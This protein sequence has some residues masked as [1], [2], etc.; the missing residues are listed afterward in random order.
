M[1]S[2]KILIKA[3]GKSKDYFFIIAFSFSSLTINAQEQ[4]EE[5]E[6]ITYDFRSIQTS[7]LFKNEP[8]SGLERLRNSHSIT[9]DTTSFDFSKI[10]Q[11]KRDR[12]I[13]VMEAMRSADQQANESE[14]ARTASASSSSSATP[15]E[16]GTA[17][18][19]VA[20]PSPSSLG[21]VERGTD[22]VNLY[23]GDLNY[24]IPLYT[25]ESRDLSVPIILSYNSASNKVDN[26]S[27][28]VGMGWSLN[29]GGLITRVMKG[30]PDEFQGDINQANGTKYTGYGWL[31]LKN[32]SMGGK[33]VRINS[34]SDFKNRWTDVNHRKN[35]IEN[36]A[37][38]GDITNLYT[39]T[40]GWDTEP[41]EFYYNFGKYS[42]K[43]VFTQDGN[44]HTVPYQEFD[45]DK[46]T[47]TVNGSEKIIGFSVLT[48][49]GVT[50]TFG[51]LDANNL[52][53]T[54]IS[55]MS[56]YSNAVVYDYLWRDYE[57]LA[58]NPTYGYCE[59]SL[60]I[61]NYFP[62]VN[63]TFNA[64][65]EWI[66]NNDN[67]AATSYPEFTSTWHLTKIEFQNDQITLTYND[68]GEINYFQGKSASVKMPNL[69]RYSLVDADGNLLDVISVSDEAPVSSTQGRYIHPELSYH[70]R[71]YQYITLQSKRLASIATS[72]G[73]VANFDSYGLRKDLIGSTRLRKIRI[74]QGTREVVAFRFDQSYVESPEEYYAIWEG[75]DFLYLEDDLVEVLVKTFDPD[76]TSDDY[77]EIVDAEHH[78]LKL[79]QIVEI[80]NGSNEFPPT[81]FHYN[82]T[83]L[84]RR[85]SADQ[86]KWGYY[87]Y[88]A[89]NVLIPP[90]SYKHIFEGSTESVDLITWERVKFNSSTTVNELI[91]MFIDKY[92]CASNN[93][94]RRG[95]NR[96][97]HANRM[98]AGLLTRID[99][100]LGGSTAFEYVSRKAA[101]N[102]KNPTVGG[103]KV[104]RISHTSNDNSN[105]EVTQFTFADGRAPNSVGLG[106]SLKSSSFLTDEIHRSYIFSS[107][108]VTTSYLTHGSGGGF[109]N[110]TVFKESKGKTLYEFI[111]PLDIE[112]K[113]AT[114][115]EYNL[116]N[117]SGNNQY[118]FAPEDNDWMRGKVDKVS[119]FREGES[120]PFLVKDYD[121]E[122]S[123]Q[124]LLWGF[125]PGYYGYRGLSLN[126]R[127][128][129]TV[130][131]GFPAYEAAFYS[132]NSAVYRVKETIETLAG[133]R[134]VN[135]VSTKTTSFDYV[136]EHPQYTRGI[137]TTYEDGSQ[138]S[139]S[140]KYVFDYFEEGDEIP[141]IAALT[142][143]GLWDLKDHDY[144]FTS[145][146]VIKKRRATDTDNWKIV[147]G[148]LSTF[149]RGSRFDSND[150]SSEVYL[151]EKKV[152]I[153][154]SPVPLSSFTEAH[155]NANKTSFINDNRYK[156]H[157]TFL[158]YNAKG[159]PILSSDRTGLKTKVTW[160]NYNSLISS[161]TSNSG[162]DIEMKTQ[163]QYEPLVGIKQVKDENNKA[164]NYIYDELNRLYMVKD[165]EG[166]IMER[167]RYNYRNQSQS[168]NFYT[169]FRT[170]GGYNLACSLVRFSSTDT[171]PYGASE[172]TWNFGDSGV[173]EDCSI[174]PGGD[175]DGPGTSQ[176]TKGKSV[177]HRFPQAGTYDV[178]VTRFSPDI[179]KEVSR[180]NTIT[181]HDKKATVKIFAADEVQ[182]CSNGDDMYSASTST[183][184]VDEAVIAPIDDDGSG[185]GNPS[186]YVRIGYDNDGAVCN[187]GG[188]SSAS[189]SYKDY[190][191][192]WKVFSN[193]STGTLPDNVFNYQSAPFTIE[194]KGTF[195]DHCSSTVYNATKTINIVQCSSGSSGGGG[196]GGGT[197]GGIDGPEEISSGGIIKE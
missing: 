153:L 162:G 81:V 124:S 110:V 72:N 25:L 12:I 122:L 181:I 143:E 29:A 113:K 101:F 51:N 150:G 68:E 103:A 161:I 16:S 148:E 175:L 53:A 41:D 27:S 14:T 190:F 128:S 165:N 176:A 85:F 177:Y 93:C 7:P 88:N 36:S 185:G 30:L 19:V 48:P 62:G 4:A 144:Q 2:N 102:G 155:F 192:N 136:E 50:Y 173:E 183:A 172:Y 17:E 69:P 61:Y 156:V 116:G 84:P 166:N 94:A 26:I 39:K 145:I 35:I 137:I 43:F 138:D 71:N 109:G 104:S 52:D 157:T 63:W 118:P 114:I 80:R 67:R 9:P 119:Y 13:E 105:G 191:G 149:Q 180:T 65:G 55:Q 107:H 159:R 164:T 111:T 168:A 42:G 163:Y 115:Q 146:E 97:A 46:T 64:A 10:S 134:D 133:D 15:G 196:T 60:E 66:L 171:D 70:S 184:G 117:Q 34:P 141:T 120:T 174:K 32:R 82:A 167:Y 77:A 33:S 187:E 132:Y 59:Y 178:T 78:R 179:G 100:P 195:S 131:V 58:E 3:L 73:I 96:N 22:M 108:P 142:A 11:Q 126:T 90:M 112:N 38:G 5:Q 8:S 91:D 18:T 45:I 123:G 130:D 49:E 79:D 75:G 40:E 140:T 92:N 6:T 186:I 147:G 189:L 154:S 160:T 74:N 1:K 158:D 76:F 169:N 125:K 188:Y 37:L 193:T 129:L 95:G 151:K 57:C 139:I 86:D 106:Y 152:L 194:V 87:N 20:L 24:K 28:E 47:A 99:H 44:I 127:G 54:E 98:K 89:S 56:S 31:K 21:K 23:T 83:K 182:D 170:S 197:G 121:Y 135:T